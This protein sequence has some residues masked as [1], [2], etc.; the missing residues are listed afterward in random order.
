MQE[1]ARLALDL[2]IS[3]T[4]P[5]Y[6]MDRAAYRTK[7]ERIDLLVDGLRRQRKVKLAFDLPRGPDIRQISD[8]SGRHFVRQRESIAESLQRFVEHLESAQRAAP[9]ELRDAIG[10]ITTRKLERDALIRDADEAWRSFHSGANKAA[11]IMAGATLEGLLQ[12]ALTR[13]GTAAQETYMRLYQHRREAKRPDG[14]TVD[15]GLAVLREAGLLSSAVAHVAR[16]MKELRNFVHPE[17]Q[18]RAKSRVRA[19]HA[20]LVLQALCTIAEE[21]AMER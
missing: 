18:R 15:E 8:L 13:L 16:G 11:V 2:T 9:E 7:L 10:R 3:L 6:G 20:L 12:A 17:V 4:P 1:A 14:M 19:S 5:A 21:L